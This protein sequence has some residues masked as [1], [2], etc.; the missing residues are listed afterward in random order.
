[1]PPLLGKP[2]D[3]LPEGGLAFQTGAFGGPEGLSPQLMALWNIARDMQKDPFGGLAPQ[4]VA[5][6]YQPSLRRLGF[7]AGKRV[8]I[9]GQPFEA[10]AGSPVILEHAASPR[11]GL[12]WGK[13]DM[14]LGL[15]HPEFPEPIPVGR[16]SLDTYAGT[17]TSQ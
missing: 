1:M 11:P 4:P 2:Y 16:A 8:G 10:S 13:H 5:G 3:T 12:G 17:N 9:P 6:I 14:Q 15:S 7:S